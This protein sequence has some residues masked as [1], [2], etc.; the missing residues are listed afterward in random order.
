[1]AKKKR[2]SLLTQQ[3]EKL[4]AQK[5]AKAAKEAAGRKALPPKGGSSASSN[6]ARYQRVRRTGKLAEKQVSNFVKAYKR[7]S[8]QRAAQNKLESA[9]K[10]TKGTEVRTGKAAP[11]KL[12]KRPSS[13]IVKS[14]KGGALAKTSKTSSAIT[15]P[16]SGRRGRA[17]AKARVAA[18]GTKGS[19]TKVA[20]GKGLPKQTPKLPPASKLKAAGRAIGKVAKPVAPGLKGI[21]RVA[22][23]LGLGI[24]GVATASDLAGSLKRGEGIVRLV[25]GLGKKG[26]KAKVTGRNR[27]GR[28]TST[29]KPVKPA[30]RGMSNIPPKEGTGKG[31]PT[32][33]KKVS[34][35]SAPKPKSKAPVKASKARSAAPSKKS[36]VH[37]YK[38]HGSAL[39][40]G[41]YKTL[42]EH[43]AAV[44]AQKKKKE[45]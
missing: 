30:K 15:K 2:K 7:V 11:G 33:K 32:D 44:A 26:P 28:A 29:T 24:S 1:M 42:K 23:P 38:K 41:R 10:G 22:G 8:R 9:A 21:G 5:A 3:R 4:K 45:K 16:S 13:A 18:K 6:K 19:G 36:A 43:R 17:A 31:S 25:K 27:R 37:T 14:G 34:K 39:H 35:V 12:A 40:V 20:G